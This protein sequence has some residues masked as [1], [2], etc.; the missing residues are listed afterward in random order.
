MKKIFT[1]I[2]LSTMV[3][4]AFGQPP[5][6]MKWKEIGSVKTL[7]AK[8]I[9][10]SR[11]SIGGETLDRNYADYEAYK[12]YLGPLGAK[13]IRLQGGW[14]RC[15]KVK[16]QY[17]FTW[18]DA[19][20]DDAIKQGVQ[21]WL[22]PSYGNPIYEGGGEAALAGG[23]PTSAEALAAWDK[24]VT[25]LTQHY[26]NRVHEWEI[27]NEPDLSNKFTAVQYARFYERTATIIRKEQPSARLIGLALCCMAWPQYA[28]TLFTHLKKNN[29]LDLI[30]VIT[31]HGYKFR[32]ED[33]Y[34]QVD[35]LKKVVYAVKPG[36]QIWQGEN[37][38]PSVKKGEAI[39][40]MREYDWSELTQAKWNL[41]R[42]FGDMGND[43]EVTNVFS[44]SD[45]YY[46]SGDHMAGYNAKG[47]LKSKPDKSIDK[48]K[49]AYYAFQYAAS[50][51]SEKIRRIKSAVFSHVP[52][53]S[54]FAYQ[55]NNSNKSM[56]T[57]WMSRKGPVDDTSENR[58]INITVKNIS[59][60]TPV[61]VDLISGKVYEIPRSN[62]KRNAGNG[63][64]FSGI[65]VPDYPILIAGKSSIVLK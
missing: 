13:R 24:W 20:V 22:Q 50:V 28:D 8:D 49:M 33:T 19:I 12:T 6:G 63:Y 60:D 61:Y 58:N 3:F 45:M 16:G 10:T 48:P 53:L 41:R 44:M 62:Y 40:A 36:V 18:L 59:I 11:W 37:G 30:D 27:W 54:V 55:K 38:A 39:G 9:K 43:F 51:F 31:I 64:V 34:R 23:I 56:V 15:E 4:S 25:A 65:P 46:S 26:K 2:F 17:D 5:E 14:A 32:P 57:L 29:T 52:D 1:G 7:N 21:P 47:L 35:D 42:M